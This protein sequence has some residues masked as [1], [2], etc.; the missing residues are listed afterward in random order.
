MMIKWF[1]KDNYQTNYDIIFKN[2]AKTN[3]KG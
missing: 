2:G 1:D 3:E